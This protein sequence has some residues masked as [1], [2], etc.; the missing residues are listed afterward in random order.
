MCAEGEKETDEFA[1]LV[2]ILLEKSEWL[3]FSQ[4]LV[5]QLRILRPSRLAPPSWAVRSRGAV[6]GPSVGPR[7]RH[8]SSPA[9]LLRHERR[10]RARRAHT[11]ELRPTSRRGRAR[12]SARCAPVSAAQVV[13]RASPCVQGLHV[14]P[15]HPELMCQAG[16]FT[17]G[18][19][20]GGE[21]IYGETFADQTFALR[22]TGP[23]ILSMNAGPDTNGSQFLSCTSKAAWLG[24]K[25]VVFGSVVDGMDVV[26]RIEAVG[27][28]SGKCKRP[29]VDGLRRG[30]P[31]VGGSRNVRNVNTTAAAARLA[32]EE[33]RR[34]EGRRLRRGS[35]WRTGPSVRARLAEGR[36]AAGRA[37]GG[38][39]GSRRRTSRRRRREATAAD[40]GPPSGGSEAARILRRRRR[41]R[42]ERRGLTPQQRRL[43]ELRLK[44]NES[45]KRTKPPS[46]RRSGGTRRPGDEAESARGAGRSRGE[47]E[48]G[49]GDEAGR[50]PGEQAPVRD[51]GGGAGGVREAEGEGPRRRR[52]RGRGLPSTTC[53]RRA[54]SGRAFPVEETLAPYERTR[55]EDATFTRRDLRDGR[56]GAKVPEEGIDRMVAELEEQK[57][58]R[59]NFSRRRKHFEERDVTH[60]NDRNENF[61]KKLDRA[62]GEHTREI[63]ANLERGTAL[64]EN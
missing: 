40:D 52:H 8:A 12:T 21:S 30:G 14:P 51:R 64:P 55:S 13:G 1:I 4:V 61:N 57:R 43:F 49:G 26:R 53:T 29:V 27:S 39:R 23:G 56:R 22:H 36:S 3:A 9:M 50:G 31:R 58:K 18:D 54:R 34:S 24:G 63:R 16:D 46:S 33:R 7:R 15:R 38:S 44:M 28:E 11:F 17:R 48:G 35:R 6:P 41:R 60:I 62:Y 2:Q 10:R 5:E 42:R 32:R 25:H 47:G 20:T 19:G 37:R 59:A 45:R